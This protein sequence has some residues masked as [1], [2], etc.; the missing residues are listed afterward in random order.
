MDKLPQE[1]LVRD[2]AGRERRKA[3]FSDSGAGEEGTDDE[4][5]EEDSEEEEEEETE[6]SGEDVSSE[7]GDTEDEKV[8][9]DMSIEILLLSSSISFYII[10]V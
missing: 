3:V 6:E 8:G 5:E 10:V 4:E 1:E 9:I 2:S 7:D